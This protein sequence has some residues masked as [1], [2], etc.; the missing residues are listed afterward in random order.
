MSGND[1][2]P[3]LGC[4]FSFSAVPPGGY[5]VIVSPICRAMRCLPP[6]G[7]IKLRV[8]NCRLPGHERMF[9]KQWPSCRGPPV[10]IGCDYVFMWTELAAS[11]T[12]C[13]SLRFPTHP[14][15]RC[16]PPPPRPQGF[17]G[18][19]RT[20]DVGSL[21]EWHCEVGRWGG[22]FLAVCRAA[23]QELK[24]TSFKVAADGR[25]P[26]CQAP[27]P[28]PP[29]L[30]SAHFHQLPRSERRGAY[31]QICP[32]FFFDLVHPPPPTPLPVSPPRPSSLTSFLSSAPPTS[33]IL[34]SALLHSS[35]PL[36]RQAC[37]GKRGRVR[38]PL[39][40]FVRFVSCV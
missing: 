39:L 13:A 3:Y 7:G 16:P 33:P 14:P 28:P 32:F 18:A 11:C 24:V 31:F 40:S 37:C 35:S 1:W 36:F 4:Y 15:L 27:L 19:V 6:G 26:A 38:D 25:D 34:P 30:L 21:V 9:R 29:M 22:G 23:Q 2:Q 20:C 8:A 5:A 12:N 10:A 17:R